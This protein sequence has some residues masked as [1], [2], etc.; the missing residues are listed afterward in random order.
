MIIVL[1]ILLL[2]ILLVVSQLFA[3]V[4][5]HHQPSF[6]RLEW[7]ELSSR[8][9]LILVRLSVELVSTCFQLLQVMPF[10]LQT[11]IKLQGPQLQWR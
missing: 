10:S 1:I 5:F 6:S 3:G 7:I 2:M 8:C 4:A 9:E 11:C